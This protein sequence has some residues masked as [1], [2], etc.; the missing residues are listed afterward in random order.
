MRIGLELS[1][2]KLVSPPEHAPGDVPMETAQVF[3]PL[4]STETVKPPP[5]ID[6]P[7]P[8]QLAPPAELSGKLEPLMVHVSVDGGDVGHVGQQSSGGF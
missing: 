1:T 7:D 5:Q 4:Q 3:E 2:W 6:P 8:S